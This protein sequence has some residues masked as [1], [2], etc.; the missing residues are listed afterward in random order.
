MQVQACWCRDKAQLPFA[1]T[2]ADGA[3]D[4]YQGRLCSVQMEIQ[5]AALL[6]NGCDAIFVEVHG[7]P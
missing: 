1:I 5:E 3:V 4:S 2:R 6:Q 7:V